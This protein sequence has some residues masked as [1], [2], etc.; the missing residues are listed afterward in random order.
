LDEIKDAIEGDAELVNLLVGDVSA[1]DMRATF[2]DDSFKVDEITKERD[3]GSTRSILATIGMPI[4]DV[5]ICA[6]QTT[7][8][9]LPPSDIGVAG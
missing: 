2:A 4:T 7:S 8:K 5:A 9:M 6:G 3:V 1:H